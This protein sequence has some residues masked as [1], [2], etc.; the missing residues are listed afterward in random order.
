MISKRTRQ[1]VYN[2]YN[3]RCAYCGCELKLSEMQ[4]DHIMPKRRGHKSTDAGTD[5]IENLYPSC[6]ICNYYK[7]MGTPEDLR[8][9]LKALIPMARRPVVFRLA[10][11]Y[12]IVEVK[13]WD[14]K[15][16]FEKMEK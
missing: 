15:F 10:E 6:H 2:K 1:L 7:G 9:R 4:V 11:K 3:G 8:K 13:E 12:G 5:N 14:G 16:Y